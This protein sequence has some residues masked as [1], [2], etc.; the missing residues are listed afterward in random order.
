MFISPRSLSLFYFLDLFVIKVASYLPSDEDNPEGSRGEDVTH[1]VAHC[2][3]NWQ[4]SFLCHKMAA[5][6]IV[7]KTGRRRLCLSL[8][9][10]I[11]VS[12]FLQC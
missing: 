10:I 5:K 9:Q 3:T 1:N 12:F 11:S 8:T 7:Q 2:A 4:I 6:L